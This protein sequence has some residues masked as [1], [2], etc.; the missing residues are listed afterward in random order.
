MLFGESLRVGDFGGSLIYLGLSLGLSPK[1][2][3]CHLDL[4]RGILGNHP[5]SAESF[6]HACEEMHL[7]STRLFGLHRLPD[8]VGV[9]MFVLCMALAS[10]LMV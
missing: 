6:M 8:S 4:I 10:I 3:S 9:L 2:L 7:D 5:E 1:A